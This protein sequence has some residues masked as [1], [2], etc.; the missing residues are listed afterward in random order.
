VRFF[1]LAMYHADDPGYRIQEAAYVRYRAH[2]DALRVT[3]PERT[4]D[5]GVLRGVHDGLMVRVF[6]DRDAQRLKLVLRCGDLQMGYFDL[7][8]EH[9]GATI[10]PEHDVVLAWVARTTKIVRWTCDVAYHEI[11]LTD[12]GCIAHRFLFHPGVWFEIPCDDLSWGCVPQP[13]RQLPRFRDRYPGGP[14]IP[15]G[16]GSELL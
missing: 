6:H 8:V 3:L 1:T 5:L 14:E 15:A 16:F 4:L 7:V 13:D 10:S 2:L 12:D 11:D 9:Y